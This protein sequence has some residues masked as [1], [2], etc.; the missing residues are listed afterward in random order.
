MYDRP[1][2]NDL[3]LP[4]AQRLFYALLSG[5]PSCLQR[6]PSFLLCCLCMH[7]KSHHVT[8]IHGENTEGGKGDGAQT[9]L[10]NIHS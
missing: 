1:V 7:R 5:E 10:T 9:T 4:H 2:R 8:H 3:P 6:F